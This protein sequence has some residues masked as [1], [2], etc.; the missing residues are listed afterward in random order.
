MQQANEQA[1]GR[2][3]AAIAT[4]QSDIINF[5]IQLLGARIADLIGPAFQIHNV[6]AS[7]ITI[8]MNEDNSA[9]ANVMTAMQNGTRLWSAIMYFLAPPAQRTQVTMAARNV[10]QVDIGLTSRY[11]LWQMMYIMIRGAW[12]AGDGVTLGSDIPQFMSSILGQEISGDAI[13]AAL[14]D[15]PMNKIPVAIVRAMPWNAAAQEIRSRLGLGLAGYRM[16]APFVLYPCRD[17]A[18]PAAIA[19]YNYARN[20]AIQPPDWALHA[21]TRSGLVT[22]QFGSLNKALGDLMHHCFTPEQLEEMTNPG[23]RL[24]FAVP[25]TGMQYR[26]WVTWGAMEAWVGVDPINL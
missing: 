16:F 4:F 20:M 14:S 8:C 12:P 26:S 10:T 17:G 25:P 3:A 9:P 6:L 7:D 2:L 15:F 22:A 21:A 13:N 5:D 23:S 24:I 1:N 19:A 18:T 11:L